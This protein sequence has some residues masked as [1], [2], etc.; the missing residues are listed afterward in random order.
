MANK[1]SKYAL[2]SVYEKKGIVEFASQ[3]IKSGYEIIAS[4]GTGS[5]LKKQKIPFVACQKISKNPDCFDGYMKT[6]SFFIESGM[7]FDRSNPVHIKEA[8]KLGVK[9]IDIV[10][11]N[12]FPVKEIIKDSKICDVK[13]IV[14][15]FDFGGPT[16]VRVAAQNFKN[17]MVVVDPKD[18]KKISKAISSENIP[19]K[20]RYYLA[21]K[22]F[23]HI[24]D[25][26]N[27]IVKYVDKK[28]KLN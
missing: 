23:K 10:I 6:M 18:Y 22:A 4:E 19:D 26:D 12:F 28:I 27:Q 15:N 7:L 8:K 25:Y 16:M 2:I 17:V 11:C 21:A 1:I 14:R 13:E 20:L 9:Q 24:L 5:E 3:L